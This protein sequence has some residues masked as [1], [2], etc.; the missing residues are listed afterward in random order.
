MIIRMCSNNQ[1]CIVGYFEAGI[2]AAET[3]FKF[4]GIIISKIAIFEE[5]ATNGHACSNYQKVI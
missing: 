1:Y 5:L 4:Q 2:F 3:Q